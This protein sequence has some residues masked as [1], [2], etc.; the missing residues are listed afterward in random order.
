MDTGS[1]CVWF[2]INNNLYFNIML[3]SATNGRRLYIL[4]LVFGR[5]VRCIYEGREFDTLIILP[6]LFQELWT[7][8]EDPPEHTNAWTESGIGWEEI[9]SG[10]IAH[11][12]LSLSLSLSSTFRL[13]LV[14]II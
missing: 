4:L 12:F 5:W 8:C 3:F 13:K 7:Y 2:E 6:W 1:T 9:S 11:I 14:I 10:K